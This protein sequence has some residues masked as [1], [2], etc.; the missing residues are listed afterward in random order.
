MLCLALA[1][2]V[3]TAPGVAAGPVALDL[4]CD[5]DDPPIPASPRGPGSL[6]IQ[7]TKPPSADADPFTDEGVTLESVYGTTPQWWTYKNGCTG[8]FIAS[9]GTAVGNIILEISGVIPNWTHAL[10]HSVVAPDSSLQALTEPVVDATRAVTESVWAP[11]MT[12]VL[13]IVGALVLWRARSGAFAGSV[14]AGAWALGVLFVVSF[15][16]QYPA[17]AVRGVDYG[18]RTVTT[19]F[20]SA[21]N[22]DA[23]K[24]AEGEDPAVAAVAGQMD[25]IVQSTQYSAW[26]SGALGDAD[27]E[28]ATKYGPDLFKATHLSW[29]EAETYQKDPSGDGAEVVKKKQKQFAQIAAE[30]ER[31]DP[32]AY[33]HLRGEHWTNR[34]TAALVNAAAVVVVCGYLLIAGLVILLS[35]ALIRLVVPFAPAAGV[36]FM[37]DRT[38]EMAV[39]S[40]KRVIGPLVM[41]PVYFLVALIL[42]RIDTSILASRMPWPLQIMIIGVLAWFAWR[43]TKPATYGIGLCGHGAGF[44]W[45]FAAGRTR[46]S[47]QDHQPQPTYSE[48]ATASAA[49]AR[50]AGRHVVFMPGVTDRPA[51]AVAGAARASGWSELHD[52]SGVAEGPS[53][54]RGQRIGQYGAPI[55]PKLR[56]SARQLYPPPPVTSTITTGPLGPRTKFPDSGHE[57]KTA[58][59][60][61]GRGIFYTNGEGEMVHS[62]TEWGGSKH[63]NPDLNWPAPNATYVVGDHQVFRTNDRGWPIEAHDP[64]VVMQQGIRS[65]HIQR[66]VGKEG[67]PGYDGGHLLANSNKGGRER[68]NV[69]AQLKELNRAVSEAFGKVPNNYYKVEKTMRTALG[70]GKDVELRVYVDYDEEDNRRP[71]M[72]AVEYTIDG[73]VHNEDFD[74]VR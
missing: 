67:G 14:H 35:Y 63:P 68:L 51:A 62:E 6:A 3:Y 18:V 12:V 47:W 32:V 23:P 27:S 57:P 22:A 33:E 28:T 46:R 50:E 60:V 37:I 72:I 13:L 45:S 21:F 7:V 70:A 73:V 30:I 1:P 66:E 4:G 19:T 5:N 34:A 44:A 8:Q 41:G 56:V 74:N 65:G 61:P 54:A 58:Y 11:W 39:G 25:D 20:I 31:A 69:I 9:A 53:T 17:E 71:T 26:L 15:L 52:S 42:L 29:A 64:Q 16:I 24:P 59:E 49:P 48:P 36:L 10:L 38:R 55:G 40:L 2:V 43:M